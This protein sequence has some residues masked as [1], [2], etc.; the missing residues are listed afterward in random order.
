MRRALPAHVQTPHRHWRR[1]CL[2]AGLLLFAGL[3][4]SATLQAQGARAKPV[5]LPASAPASPRWPATAPLIDAR[6]E[7]TPPGHHATPE[8]LA[9][10]LTEG[11]TQD[12]EKLY[13]LYRWV[14]R[15]IRYDTAA[16]FAGDLRNAAGSAN[17]FSRGQA[18]CDGYA[19]LLQVMARAVGLKLEKVVGYGKGLSHS[20]G[21]RM[22]AQTNHAWNAV[23][24]GGRWYLMDATWDAGSV[25]ASTRQFVRNDK[26]FRYF[27]ADPEYFSTSHFPAETRWQLQREPMDFGR[28]LALAKIRP[29]IGAFAFDVRAHRER[30]QGGGTAPLA[31]DFGPA[32]QHLTA[33]MARDGRRLEGAW[34][35]LQRGPEGPRL[36]VAAPEAGAYELTVFAPRQ[37][38]DTV[39]EQLLEYRVA[40][41]GPGPYAQGFATTFREYG[42]RE[43]ELQ[44]PLQGV[45]P[46]TQP[47]RFDLRVPEAVE[48]FLIH[49]NQTY[50]QLPA[51]ADG[52]HGGELVLGAGVATV[53]ARFDAQSRTG[54]ALLRYR[55]E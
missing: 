40:L 44:A 32:V 17:A 19:E 15:H 3:L 16:Y 55:A 21:S 34:T 22:P 31:F 46:A 7:A 39:L 52:R 41:T 38:A 4:P 53:Y 6:A 24:L 11:L 35:L 50:T 23:Q 45:L 8:A 42:Q 37:P 25:N 12:V 13:A 28:F 43:V 49:G 51:R 36:L 27:L 20:D 48:V 18:V 29:D 10:A 47:V 54:Q 26:G 30:A 33:Y 2:N 14:T 5:A 9:L 1:L